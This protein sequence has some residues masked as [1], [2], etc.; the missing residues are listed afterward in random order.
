[1]SKKKNILIVDEKK[2]VLDS[3]QRFFTAKEFD[4]SIANSIKDAEEIIKKEIPF[5]IVL[6]DAHFSKT[7]EKATGIKKAEELKIKF[8]KMIIVVMSNYYG[9]FQER[10]IKVDACL[11]KP[12]Q[13]ESLLLILENYL[14]NINQKIDF[15]K[16]WPNQDSMKLLSIFMHDKYTGLEGVTNDELRIRWVAYSLKSSKYRTIGVSASKGCD[17][18]CFNC[19]SQENG[20]ERE[21]STEEI[22]SQVFHGL[23]SSLVT[24]ALDE[25]IT[26]KC[27]KIRF[28]VNSTCGG[29]W[30]YVPNPINTLKAFWEIHNLPDV[31]VR[32]IL[33]SV[34]HV[35]VLDNLLNS[36]KTKFYFTEIKPELYLSLN[37]PFAWQRDQL[38]KGTKGQNI[39]D[40]IKLHVKASKLTGKKNTVSIVLYNGINSS[41][42]HAT[43]IAEKLRGHEDFLKIKIQAGENIPFLKPLDEELDQFMKFIIKHNSNLECKIRKIVGGKHKFGCGTTVSEKGKLPILQ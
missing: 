5:D 16:N 37:F 35:K 10:L 29:D 33:T 14:K 39:D 36:E 26:G 31:D 23:K 6:M 20:L 12:F 38:M 27:K 11:K 18:K 32:F 19:L 4:V 28:G 30:L 24:N 8:P 2:S 41:C 17:G 1:M 40:L 34:G 15:L 22:L 25:F 3:L 21:L 42:H 9:L 7:G 13:P 43:A